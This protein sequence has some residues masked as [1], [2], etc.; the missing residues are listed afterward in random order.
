MNYSRSSI[1]RWKLGIWRVV[2][3]ILIATL[4][5]NHTGIAQDL[6]GH[7][8]EQNLQITVRIYDYSRV[9]KQVLTEARK[10]TAHILKDAGIQTKWLA[11]SAGNVDGP[12]NIGCRRPFG[13][14][15]LMIN[16]LPKSMGAKLVVP[17]TALGYAAIFGGGGWGYT[18]W[19]FYYKVERIAKE[20]ITDRYHV[21][22][23]VIAHEIGHLLLHTSKHRRSGLMGGFW[24]PKELRLA[25]RGML[26][27][28]LKEAANLR[29]KLREREQLDMVAR[30]AA[31][32]YGLAM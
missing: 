11:C 7:Q 12:K 6:K 21:L 8:E 22:A 26:R 32:T 23:Y 13:P 20:T 18:S 27:F 14:N 5:V 2:P 24:G 10:E 28:T 3:A 4:A 31:D 25:S 17:P 30:P 15:D 1:W 19:V 9:K 29:A 16:I